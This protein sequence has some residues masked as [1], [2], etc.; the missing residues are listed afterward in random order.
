MCQQCDYSELLVRSGINVTSHRLMV[1]EIIGNSPS[2]VSH[3]E[4]FL[5]LRASHSINRVTVYRVLDL[6]VERGVIE[7]LSSGDRSF[8]YGLAPGPN[9]PEHSHFF[10]GE[11]GRMECLDPAAVKI[12]LRSIAK[13]YPAKI[14]RVEIRLDGICE[15]CLKRRKSTPGSARK[16][17]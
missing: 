8:R 9:H 17:V 6:L 12:D 16:S 1:L 13:S 15:D 11:C 14:Q 3:Q 5:K 4:I 10:C 2:P 7:R